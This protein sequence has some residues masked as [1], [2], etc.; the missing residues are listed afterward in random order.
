MG[1]KLLNLH[2][3]LMPASEHAYWTE[4]RTPLSRSSIDMLVEGYEH[5]G[6]AKIRTYQTSEQGYA[7]LD[8]REASCPA[9]RSVNG[10]TFFHLSVSILGLY[11][12]TCL[13]SFTRKARKRGEVA[14]QS[15][16]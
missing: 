2:G 6:C 5:K 15:S 3:S 12:A 9:I 16:E 14:R 8:V 10:S 11:Q 4:R 1:S 7:W 13:M